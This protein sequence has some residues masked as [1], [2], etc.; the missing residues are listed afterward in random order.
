MLLASTVFVAGT[1]EIKANS[2]GSVSAAQQ[3]RSGY[4]V[5]RN[6][7]V[8]RVVTRTRTF[9]SGRQLVRE[10]Y[11]TTYR[12]NGRVTTRIISRTVIRRY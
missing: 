7:R 4:R 9:R 11:Q 8:A 6:G 3:V 12:P 10:T 1:S 5:Q 2:L